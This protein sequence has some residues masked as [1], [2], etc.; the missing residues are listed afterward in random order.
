MQTITVNDV[1]PPAITCPADITVPADAGA[2]S[3]TLVP[4]NLQPFQLWEGNG[5]YAH[6]IDVGG[7]HG[8]VVEMS[9]PLGSVSSAAVY[10][11]LATPVLFDSIS[12]LS[13]D[14]NWLAGTY[15][16]GAP[17]F[18]L[19]MEMNWRKACATGT[20][21]V[22]WGPNGYAPPPGWQSNGNFIGT[23]PTFGWGLEQLAPGRRVRDELDTGPGLLTGHNVV[24]INVALDGGGGGITQTCNWTISS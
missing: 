9:S 7:T 20:S 2:C 5:G 22:Y 15:N 24:S 6:L 12:T 21:Y 23:T 14:F 8:A 13:A 17:R 19:G 10:A 11:R 3:A 4:G 18:S 16:W 1:T